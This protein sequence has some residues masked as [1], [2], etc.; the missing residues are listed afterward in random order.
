[1][2]MTNKLATELIN[3]LACVAISACG[4]PQTEEEFAYVSEYARGTFC[5]LLVRW[6]QLKDEKWE[7]E[8]A[9]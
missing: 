7:I 2:R 4:I 5:D 1:M 8:E 6:E 9:E 3:N